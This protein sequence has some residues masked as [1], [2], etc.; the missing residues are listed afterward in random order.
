MVNT[1]TSPEH[2]LEEGL[3]CLQEL[4]PA[5]SL[6]SDRDRILGL[7]GRY[8]AE[9]ELFNRAYGLVKAA[10]SYELI[11]KHILD[12]LAPVDIIG[13]IVEERRLGKGGAEEDC[14]LNYPAI[15]DAGSGAGLPGIPL[16][17]VLPGCRF[18]LIEKMGRR[19]G[20][21][22]NTLAVLGL[23][24]AELEEIEMEQAVPGRF[25][26]IVFRAFKSMDNNLFKGLARLLAPG[27]ILAA[28]KGRKEKT[29][30]EIRLVER[31][32]N[33]WELIP[34][35]VPFLDEKRHL[36]IMEPSEN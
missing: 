23:P 35:E 15:A 5:C 2:V 16:A 32:V 7:L 19:A 24:N 13:R 25:D 4:Y 11:V 3:I 20:F 12:S 30:E 10:D 9:I 1:S 34:L 31:H 6:L 18:T 14:A 33:R 36:L 8:I 17:I 22:R 21:L 26:V 29:L 27:G 28:Y